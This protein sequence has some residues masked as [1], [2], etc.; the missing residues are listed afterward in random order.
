QPIHQR[1]RAANVPANE[2]IN[3][4][5]LRLK[6]FEPLNHAVVKLLFLGSGSNFHLLVD[7]A[8]SVSSNEF[9]FRFTRV[10]DSDNR[11]AVR[12][13]FTR[14]TALRRATV[15]CDARFHIDRLLLMTTA[16]RHVMHSIAF[17][18]GRIA[19]A[20]GDANRKQPMCIAMEALGVDGTI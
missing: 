3:P 15:M 7:P 10:V 20:V 17:V 13:S 19:G 8:N 4:R 14:T 2:Q 18:P 9:R 5:M 11:A 6:F 1:P 16:E 12:T